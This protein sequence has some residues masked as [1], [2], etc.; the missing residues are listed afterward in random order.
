MK[1]SFIFL[2]LLLSS[3][4]GLF[5]QEAPKSTTTYLSFKGGVGGALITDEWLSPLRY[6]GTSYSLTGEGEFPLMKD[7]PWMLRL[8]TDLQ[9]AHVLNPAGNASI[10]YFRTELIPEVMY[11]LFLPHGFSL[12]VGPGICISG[13]TRSHSRNGNNPISVDAKANLTAAV[14]VGWRVPSYKWP[15]AFRLYANINTI[16]VGNK[17]GYAESYFE[18]EFVDKGFIHSALFMHWGNQLQ[19]ILAFT[20]DVPLWNV[21]TLQLGYKMNADIARISDRKRSGIT[22][23]GMVGISFETLWFRGRR[24]ASSDK[25]APYLF[26]PFEL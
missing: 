15:I 24:A 23:M 8:A 16:G 25:A 11:R 3:A 26:K 17:I 12:A 22:H 9:Y 21:L 1:Q 5:S 13:G 7:S 20:V 10:D 4:F 14:L 18:Q 19:S 6:G 2:I